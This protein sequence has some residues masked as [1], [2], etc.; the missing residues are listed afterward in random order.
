MRYRCQND[1]LRALCNDGQLE[2]ALE[3]LSYMDGAGPS[4]DTYI[5]LLRACQKRKD[6]VQ[7][8]RVY[9]YLVQN[10]WKCDTYINDYL[11]M[12]FAKCGAIEDALDIARKLPH[13]TVYS[14]TALISAYTELGR[15]REAVALFQFMQEDG[16]KPN[17]YTFVSLLKACGTTSDLEKGRIFH[18]EAR[19]MGFG[20]DTILCTTLVSMYGKCG[21]ITE[22]ENVF[23]TL[24][25]RDVVAWNAMLAA[26]V[27]QGMAEKA[28]HLYRQMH[29]ERVIIDQLMFVIAIQ[30]CSTLAEKQE[31]DLIKMASLEIGKSLHAD[32]RRGGFES[33]PFMFSSIVHMYSKCYAIAEA[34]HV[35]SAALHQRNNV[36]WNVMIS[37]YFDNE[38][39]KKALQ[40]YRHM[41]EESTV[42]DQYSFTIALQACGALAEKEEGFEV[43][44]QRTKV[45]SLEIA[46]ALHAD[47]QRLN[48]ASD[49]FINN[50]LIRIYG[51]CG[52]ITDA[53]DVFSKISNRDIVSWNALLSA[54][55]EHNQGEMALCL[56]RKMKGEK[57]IPDH[58]AFVMTLQACGQLADKEEAI[59]IDGELVKATTLEIGRRL[60]LDAQA[61][62]FTSDTIVGDALIRMYSRCGAILLAEEIFGALCGQ[63]DV[64]S[65]TAMLSAYAEQDLGEKALKLYRQ[66]HKEGVHADQ[67]T[68]VVALQ[69]CGTFAEKD[70][71]SVVNDQFMKVV[72]LEIGL[73]L[74]ADARRKGFASNVFIN[75]TLVSMYG[76]CGAIDHAENVFAGMVYRDA[77]SW[78]AMLS[79][80][81]DQGE[82]VLQ[83]FKQMQSEGFNPDELTYAIAL[84]A[85]S[86]LS[87]RENSKTMY[88]EIGQRIH[89]D[90]KSK[91]YTSGISINN[92][93][94]SM[95]G[96]C[97]TIPEAEDVF[98]AM[99]EKDPVSWTAMLSAYIEQGQ[100]EKAFELYKKMQKEG[101]IHDEV[102]LMCILQ[103]CSDI[104][105]LEM[106]KH[107][108]FIIVV[109]GYDLN[110]TLSVSV[111]H[112]YGSG[113]SMQ[114][115]EASFNMLRETYL[116][117]CNACIASNAA[118]GDCT[119]SLRKFEELQL[120]G[121]KADEVT[122]ISVLVACS[123]AGLAV[124]GFEYFMYMVRV[125]G[126]HVDLK[127]YGIIV[128]LLG[129][130]GD[131]R[132]A[133][134]I[135]EKISIEADYAIWLSLLGAC[136]IHGN[137]EVGERA[138]A[139]ALLLQPKQST[140]SYVLM[141]NIYAEREVAMAAQISKLIV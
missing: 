86:T 127:H 29:E 79:A 25:Q 62:A 128:D 136:R 20:V 10:E 138:F 48:F 82:R 139:R 4:P 87:E 5:C 107:Q 123:H 34:E 65:W 141:S 2:R 88:Y 83:L 35:F 61:L 47:A 43:E 32:A 137:V 100:G 98:V 135:L 39:E 105:N 108:H 126:C 44:G 68:F 93:I 94:M 17:H 96:K 37:A 54:Y 80:Y 46:K 103:V 104:G 131:F 84:Q 22:A 91:G 121:V 81:I 27:E 125:C 132:R 101:V 28:L 76:K 72:P 92:T 99:S 41:Q 95:Y 114:D 112:A 70:E 89:G 66:M 15:G 56:Y 75:N 14:W 33:G 16:V 23:G 109:F 13:R 57:V 8:K 49:I 45:V 130:A 55:V 140:A 42:S 115:A 71:T 106:C 31:G 24:F 38:Q 77:I 97:G 50:T 11:V 59:V 134:Y 52:I 124:K 12:T 53:E 133:E 7:V 120:M 9:S 63:H 36:A 6:L 19:R 116:P 119:A 40:L 30:A 26:Y 78:N 102:T 113:A 111:I 60:H 90:A 85:C 69:A 18:D 117:S 118:E 129:R 67:H 58:L 110:L 122:F 74:H 64:R 3:V 73:A 21:A 1:S 51:K